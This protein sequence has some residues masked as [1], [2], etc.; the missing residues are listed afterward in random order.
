M[1]TSR[2]RRWRSAMRP[3]ALIRR[4]GRANRAV[5]YIVAT[6]DFQHYPVIPEG[7]IDMQD[8]HCDLI[9]LFG[10]SNPVGPPLRP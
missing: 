4:A 6:T 2:M 10:L 1:A 9:R 7:A 5:L 8:R 3:K